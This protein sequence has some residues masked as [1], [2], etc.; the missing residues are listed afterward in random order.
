MFKDFRHGYIVLTP[1]S[2]NGSKLQIRFCIPDQKNKNLIRP[3]FS[4]YTLRATAG[5]P[6]V[7]GYLITFKIWGL[8]NTKQGYDYVKDK[9]SYVLS[10]QIYLLLRRKICQ[11][12]LLK[13]KAS[14]GNGDWRTLSPWLLPI[15][16]LWF[17]IFLNY[18]LFCYYSLSVHIVRFEKNAE[19]A[20][21]FSCQF[22]I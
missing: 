9:Q 20:S 13:N 2:F 21:S 14:A 6:Y 1:K 4:K 3:F 10:S 15:K 17:A 18:S 7:E 12:K 5:T 22:D 16:L 8:Y 11:Q 19:F